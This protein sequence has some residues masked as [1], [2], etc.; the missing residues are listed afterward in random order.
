MVTEREQ[1][2]CKC[3]VEKYAETLVKIFDHIKWS[4][5]GVET[6]VKTFGHY[7]VVQESVLP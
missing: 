7:K 5:N 4:K 3:L 1:G 6:L 2:L